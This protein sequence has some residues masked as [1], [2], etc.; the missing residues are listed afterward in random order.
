M[1]RFVHTSD[2]Q[3]GTPFARF[4]T[5]VGSRLREARI[6]ALDRVL[7]LAKERA[8]DFVLIAGDLFDNQTLPDAEI[9]RTCDL[10]RGAERPV[11]VI[12]GNHDHGGPGSIWTDAR[13]VRHKPDALGLCLDGTPVVTADGRAVVLPAPLLRRHE[14]G[15]P[16]RH[17]TAELGAGDGRIRVAFA[18]G[19]VIGFA[20]EGDAT[21]LLDPGLVARAELDYLA[22]GDWHGTKKISDRAWYSGTPEVDRFKA[23]D[24][25]HALVVTIA[26]PRAT[27]QVEVV[28]TT[29]YTWVRHDASIAGPSDVSALE[30]WFAAIEVPSRTLVRLE[31]AGALSLEEKRRLE[32]VVLRDAAARLRHVRRRGS[33]IVALPSDD[34]LRAMTI[35]GFVGAAVTELRA[36]AGDDPAASRALELLHALRFTGGAGC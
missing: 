8:A 19:G 31:L 14:P 13:F 29:E 17:I 25:G 5:D 26:A 3:I 33:D 20:N 24:P 6:D 7:R 36:R 2:L 9:V 22:L 15:D 1:I 23:N 16:S 21:N 27:P 28:R 30:A 4:P 34:E 10:I 35:D 11:F 12:P 32:D 18:H